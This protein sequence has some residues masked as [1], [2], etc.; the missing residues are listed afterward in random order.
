MKISALCDILPH[1]IS[2]HDI[3]LDIKKKISTIFGA[4]KTKQAVSPPRAELQRLSGTQRW[5]LGT[6]Y[7]L[8]FSL[9]LTDTLRSEYVRTPFCSRFL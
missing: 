2:H 7:W 8:S 3:E 1:F 5:N 6:V 9:G 4:P